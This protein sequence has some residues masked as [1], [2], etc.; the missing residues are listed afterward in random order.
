MKIALFLT[1]CT[2]SLLVLTAPCTGAEEIQPA[3]SLE[4]VFSL[5]FNPQNETVSIEVLSMGCTRKQS[6]AFDLAGEALTIIRLEP[7][8]CKM[9]PHRVILTYTGRDVLLLRGRTFRLMNPISYTSGRERLRG[10][11]PQ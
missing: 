11:R 1:I 10:Q 9:P 2:A 7:D 6:F 5:A 4:P 8:K 3:L